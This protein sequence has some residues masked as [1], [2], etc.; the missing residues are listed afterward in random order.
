MGRS[1]VVGCRSW[2]EGCRSWVLGRV[3]LKVNK[4]YIIIIIIIIIII[5]FL[6][7]SQFFYKR[8]KVITRIRLKIYYKLKA[9]LKRCVFYMSMI[10]QMYQETALPNVMWMI[11]RFICLLMSKIVM[12]PFLL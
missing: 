12:M 8:F 3:C 4:R 1:W 6:R 2:V 11:Q 10:C 9:I 7:K 5:Q